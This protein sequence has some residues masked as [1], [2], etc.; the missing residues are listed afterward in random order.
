MPEDS[1]RQRIGVA[2]KGSMKSSSVSWRHRRLSVSKEKRKLQ[3]CTSI[4]RIKS[5][6]AERQKKQAT[7][8]GELRQKMSSTGRLRL[9][10]DERKRKKQPQ[11]KKTI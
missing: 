9:T 3:N 7:C 1:R 5:V 8:V 11:E 10:E 4:K 2:G 6:V